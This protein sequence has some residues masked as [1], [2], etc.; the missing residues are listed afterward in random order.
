MSVH[1]NVRDDGS[2]VRVHVTTPDGTLSIAVVDGDIAGVGRGRTQ[3][4]A[5]EALE[6]QLEVAL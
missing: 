1:A 4:D 3:E 6:A 2:Q 5:K